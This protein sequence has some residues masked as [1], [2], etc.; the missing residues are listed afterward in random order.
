MRA[1][2]GLARAFDL[3]TVAE[4][5]DDPAQIDLL[6]DMGCDFGQG[7]PALPLGHPF[8][9]VQS[10]PYWSSTSLV[11]APDAA[12]TVEFG[13]GQRTAGSKVDG[14]PMWPVRGGLCS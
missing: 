4:G 10:L 1:V 6:R 2:L 11:L 8:S 13:F 9:G 5:I 12:W 3:E 14:A 7:F